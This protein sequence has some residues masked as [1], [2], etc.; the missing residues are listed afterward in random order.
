[1]FKFDVEGLNIANLSERA[2]VSKPTLETRVSFEESWGV[3]IDEQH[4]MESA[5]TRIRRQD[6]DLTKIRY[7]PEP[8]LGY[9]NTL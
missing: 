7:L 1:M 4:A 9:V 6:L 8:T 3:C 2:Q 5:F